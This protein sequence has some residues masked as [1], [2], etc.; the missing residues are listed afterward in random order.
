MP[1]ELNDRGNGSYEWA[2]VL[3]PASSCT[4]AQ[5][6]CPGAGIAIG[7]TVILLHP[8]H[9]AGV[10]IEME[11]ERQQSRQWLNLG[12]NPHDPVHFP[13]GDTYSEVWRSEDSLV[14]ELLCI[15]PWEGRHCGGWCVHA[16]KMWGGDAAR[17]H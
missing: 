1:P 3:A 10:S 17:G 4:V 8:L 11:R 13:V 15:A 6:V 16:G 12:W 9:V 5:R 7:E 2:Q 14:W